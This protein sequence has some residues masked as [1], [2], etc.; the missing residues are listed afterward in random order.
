M[1]IDTWDQRLSEQ[2]KREFKTP[3]V[4]IID[5]ST[6]RE[7]EEKSIPGDLLFVK[8]VSSKSASA[9]IRFNKATNEP[10]TLKHRTKIHTVF[11]SFYITNTAQAGESMTLLIGIN[12]DIQD[13]LQDSSEVQPAI[14]ITNALA[15]TN[16]AGAA[17]VC[18]AAIIKADVKNTQTA[19]IDFGKAAVQDACYPLDPGEWIEVPVSNTD[20][21]NANF[22]VGGEKVFVAYEV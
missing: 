2:A 6:A 19:W 4:V 11:K 15:D 16:Q 18:N 17:H 7:N 12:F 10:I 13:I 20:R 8:S 3:V 9:T 1:S 22:E 14:I 5:L 21:I